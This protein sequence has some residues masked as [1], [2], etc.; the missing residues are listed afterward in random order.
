MLLVRQAV[1]F[2]GQKSQILNYRQYLGK[3]ASK[4]QDKSRKWIREAA[5]VNTS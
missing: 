5:K 1:N 2:S 3:Q 4:M